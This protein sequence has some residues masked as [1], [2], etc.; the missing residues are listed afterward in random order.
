LWE[1]LHFCQKLTR[2]S[3]NN[4]IQNC[5]LKAFPSAHR[6]ITKTI[7]Q[8]REN[9]PGWLTRGITYLP[10]KPGDSKEVRN[11]WPTVCL[12]TRYKTLTGITKRI[13]THLEEQ[14]LLPAEQE[15]YHPGSKGCKDK[16]IISTAIFEDC[17]RRNKHLSIA[18]I[19]YQKAFD[20]ISH[21]GVEK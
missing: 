10:P 13:S 21:N 12:A 19:D 16:L 5:W 17:K 3:G 20:S 2:I 18:W 14:N 11:Y 4:Q 6:P 9:F 7:M 1:S 8:E 15:G